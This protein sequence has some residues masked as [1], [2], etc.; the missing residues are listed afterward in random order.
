MPASAVESHDDHDGNGTAPLAPVVPLSSRR[1]SPEPPV[2]EVDDDPLAGMT[3][4]DHLELAAQH[5]RETLAQAG[6]DLH[7]PQPPAA[8]L[9]VAGDE[10][11]RLVTHL[12]YATEGGGPAGL[13]PNP[14]IGM[15]FQAALQAIGLFREMGAVGDVRLPES[16]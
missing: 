4:Q 13:A 3:E 15:T 16:R 14:E 12:L 8:V 10:L 9:R 11:E 7:T 1:R 2:P 5:W 6:M